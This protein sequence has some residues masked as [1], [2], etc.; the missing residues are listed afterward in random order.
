[1]KCNLIFLKLSDPKLEKIIGTN[2]IL[3]EETN[4]ESKIK[5]IKMLM[6][7]IEVYIF[8]VSYYIKKLLL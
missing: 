1:L 7:V 4:I 3:K 5:N 8:K 2:I 6:E